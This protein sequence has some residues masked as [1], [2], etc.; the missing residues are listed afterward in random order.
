MKKHVVT[1]A[2]P[3][4]LG[5]GQCSCGKGFPTLKAAETH[6]DEQNLIEANEEKAKLERTAEAVA[7]AAQEPVEAP[8]EPKVVEAPAKPVETAKPAPV[9]QTGAIVR[10][11]SPV[12]ITNMEL[13]DQMVL[14]Y[15]TTLVQKDEAAEFQARMK[16]IQRI[17]PKLANVSPQ[18]L[19]T[20]MM[21][22]VHLRLMPNTT[23]GLAY[24]IPYGNEAQFQIGYKGLAELAYR[25]GQ[26]VKIDQE[27]VFEGDDF[28]WSLGLHRKLTHKPNPAIDRTK[29]DNLMATYATAQ[30]VDGTIVF[31]V[32]TKFELDKIRDF[33]KAKA[34][35]SPW[36]LWPVE[37]AK[38]TATIRLAKLLPKSKEDNR[39]K[40]AAEIDGIQA[41]GKRLVVDAETGEIFGED[42]NGVPAE[43]QAR[44]DEAENVE[45]LQEI[46]R[47]LSVPEQKKVAGAVMAKL[48]SLA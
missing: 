10:H 21:A 42:P 29:Y 27:A 24:I 31:Q 6:A 16:L 43:I 30:L 5:G 12:A 3:G 47:D 15:A 41:A 39:L 48:R 26:V 35:D 32:V 46:V 9:A 2:A 13:A 25:T 19:F 33:A 8:V 45:A 11:G 40:V 17:N 7:P 1:K 38:K 34:P 18:S 14:K 22:C 20:A 4:Q 36:K 28:D 23:E 37:Q 44:I